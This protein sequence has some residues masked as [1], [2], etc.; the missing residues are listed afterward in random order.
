MNSS[1]L[2]QDSKIKMAST[3]GPVDT[4]IVGVLAE[5]FEEKTGISIEYEKAGT[6]KALNMAKTG[7]FDLVIVH[8][9]A[10]EEKF[11]AEGYGEERIAVM[12]NDFV[13]IGPAS[14][15]A[16]IQGLSLPEALE[17]IKNKGTKFI[18]RGDM[19]GTHVKEMELWDNAGINP[20]GAWYVVWEGGAKGNSATLKYTDEQQA[21]T[22]IDR[23][24]YLSLKKDITIV[25]LVEGDDALL[26]FISVIPISSQKFPHVNKQLARDFIA[27]LTSEEGQ[28]IIRDF[29]QDIYGEPLYFPNS[30]EWHKLKK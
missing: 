5:K 22:I 19:S 16:Q 4:G 30:D 18:S 25:P 8:A 20:T 1:I 24:T 12:Y 11:I 23:A 13:I 28:T 27:F 14:D 2:D 17:K 15:P 9:K 26:N 21:Y 29:K 3:I 7:C 6:G 10:L